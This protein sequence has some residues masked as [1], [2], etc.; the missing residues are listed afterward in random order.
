MKKIDE[1]AKNAFINKKKFKLKN[2]KVE[3]IRDLPHLYLHDNLIA[4]MDEYGDLLINHCGWETV[5]TKSRLN[6]LP[7]VNIKLSKGKF[8]LNKMEH[9]EEEWININRLYERQ[10]SR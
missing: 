8:Y 4:K 1:L 6:A 10:N 2:T 3:I 9:M 5:T 7:D